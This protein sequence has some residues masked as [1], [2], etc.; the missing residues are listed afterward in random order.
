[1]KTRVFVGSVGSML[2]VSFCIATRLVVWESFAVTEFIQ[3]TFDIATDYT[4]WTGVAAAV[5]VL[6]V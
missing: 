4:T 3:L 2:K 6:R 1:M 5:V